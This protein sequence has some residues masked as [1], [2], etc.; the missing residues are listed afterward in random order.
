MTDRAEPR[1]IRQSGGRPD[2]EARDGRK[3]KENK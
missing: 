2:G 1:T 3:M